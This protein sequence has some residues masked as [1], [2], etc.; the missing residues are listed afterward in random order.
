MGS[1]YRAKYPP[2]GMSYMEAQAT[3]RLRQAGTW[4]LKYRDA[5]GIVRR[6]AT[7]LT[8]HAEAKRRLKLREGRTAEGKMILP[9]ADKVAVAEILDDLKAE[10]RANNRRSS[11]RLGTSLTHL[12]RAFGG[13]RAIQIKAGDITRYITQRQGEG[14]ANATINRE[15][16]ALKRAYVLAM[17]GEKLHERPYIPML[18]EANARKG[19]FAIQEFQ[20]VLANLPDYLKP[21]FEVAHLTGWRVKSEILTR[22]VQHLDLASGWLRLE[23]NETKTGEGRMFPLIPRLREVMERQRGLADQQGTQWL[24]TRN[25][26]P[27]KSFRRAWQTACRRAGVPGRIPHDFRRTAI[28]NLE[29]SGIARSAAM[30][31]VGHR[32]DS[33]YRRYAVA[34]E[35]TLRE[36]GAKLAS[37]S[38]AAIDRCLATAASTPVCGHSS[39]HS[40]A[41][42]VVYAAAKAAGKLVGRDGIE[43]PTPGFSVLCSTN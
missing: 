8:D 9:R 13:H 5:R 33:V 43:P 34:D 6:E 16:A 35:T 15:L 19:F 29:R 30:A 11:A 40:G 21:V 18:R 27:I 22:Q 25:G 41:I 10:Y 38:E 7:G 26:K 20:A 3:G 28:R 2:Q 14:A 31:L 36:A 17:R 4:T 23:P 32:T 37:L 39:E 24:F 1:L 12:L 42:E